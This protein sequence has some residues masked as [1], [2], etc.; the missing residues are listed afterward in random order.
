MSLKFIL[1]TYLYNNIRTKFDSNKHPFT[2]QVNTLP[3]KLIVLQLKKNRFD[4][5]IWVTI[6]I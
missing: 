1:Y 5:Y 6:E 4:L 3:I 2:R